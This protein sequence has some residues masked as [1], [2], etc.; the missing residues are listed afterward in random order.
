MRREMLFLFKL[1]TVL[2]QGTDGNC[3]AKKQLEERKKTLEVEKTPPADFVCRNTH[4]EI[5]PM[6]IQTSNVSLSFQHGLIKS[7]E[8]HLQYMLS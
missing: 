5:Y 6:H 7:P 3:G 4:T 8:C 2:L 1:K